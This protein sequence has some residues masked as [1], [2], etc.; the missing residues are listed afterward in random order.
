MNEVEKAYPFTEKDY[1]EAVRRVAR[2]R[3]AS[4]TGVQRMGHKYL[5][6]ALMI[7]R[8]EKEGIIAPYDGS[9]S[10]KILIPKPAPEMK[11]RKVELLKE[12]GEYEPIDFMALKVFDIFR[13]YEVDS[14]ELIGTFMADS[15]AYFGPYEVII[16]GKKEWRDKVGTIDCT[17]FEESRKFRQ[18]ELR[19]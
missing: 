19:P 6:A 13:L 1:Q 10:R 3:R 12:S 11:M 4:V 8:M 7:D 16:D 18:G 5:T 17:P 15:D 14:E 9:P 2:T